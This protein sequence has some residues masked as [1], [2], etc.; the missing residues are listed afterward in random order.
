MKSAE[1]CH[2]DKALAVKMACWTVEWRPKSRIVVFVWEVNEVKRRWEINASVGTVQA[3]RYTERN[4]TSTKR[5][6]HIDSVSVSAAV[7][8]GFGG[9]R[10]ASPRGL[11]VR[12]RVKPN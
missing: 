4:T 10:I 8:R 12:G 6:N 2:S 3:L 7:D 9:I 1:A 11:A 5:A